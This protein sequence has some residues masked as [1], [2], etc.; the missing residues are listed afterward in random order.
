M[1]ED[2]DKKPGQI[3]KKANQE[4]HKKEMSELEKVSKESARQTKVQELNSKI[5][6]GFAKAENL[7]AIGEDKLANESIDALKTLQ[8]SLINNQNANAL[9]AR[10]ADLAI[11]D[12][13]MSVNDAALREYTTNLAAEEKAT[14]EAIAAKEKRDADRAFD[15]QFKQRKRVEEALEKRRKERAEK[16]QKENLS[17]LKGISE[18]MKNNTEALKVSDDMIEKALLDMGPIFAGEVDPAFGELQEELR[19]VQ[20]LEKAGQV[21]QEE[22]NEIRQAILD[23]TTDREKEREAQKAAELQGMALTKLGDSLGR[24]GDKLGEF[25]QGAV[26][27]GGLLAGLLGFIIGMVDPEKFTEIMINITNGFSEIVAGFMALLSGDFDTFKTK[28]GE[29]FKLFGG[30]VLG[31]ALYFGGPLITAFGGIFKNLARVVRAIKVFR[32]FMIGL[33]SPT[34]LS[35]LGTMLA[36][37]GATLVPLLPIVAIIGVIVAAFML[38]KNYLGEGASLTDTLKYAMLLLLDGLGHIVNAFTFIPR[39]IFGFFGERI[40]KFLLGDDF[41]MPSFITQ[42][43]KTNRA[44]TFK[45]EIDARKPNTSEI[46]AEIEAEQQKELEGIEIPENLDGAMILEGDDALDTAKMGVAAG[47]ATVNANQITANTQS[48]SSSVTNIAYEAP[49]FSTLQLQQFYAGRA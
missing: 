6:D 20:E 16:A 38:I 25:G 3:I 40:G 34:M 41:K 24:V 36:G 31:L 47:G 4:Q 45:A 15:K 37:L 29:N 19:K 5:L 13:Q 46:D 21:T 11:I 28:I 9:A 43:M 2:P 48:S 44:A 30:L 22:S 12:K 32:T 7:R 42:G 49:S 17:G 14:A 39:K 35:T 1:A 23:A 26:K 33:F 10:E 8:Q 27:T 18:R